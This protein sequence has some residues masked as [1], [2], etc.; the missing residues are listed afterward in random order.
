ME[1]KEKRVISYSIVF[2]I[3]SKCWELASIEC[4]VYSTENHI[5]YGLT[6]NRFNIIIQ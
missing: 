3:L 5:S 1:K 2:P 4:F 6:F